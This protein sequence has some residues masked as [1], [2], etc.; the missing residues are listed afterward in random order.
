MDDEQASAWF[1]EGETLDDIEEVE[2]ELE[3]EPDGAPDDAAIP[4]LRPP[5]RLTFLAVGVGAALLLVLASV[6]GH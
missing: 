6:T 1:A 4:D 5:Y 3:A 2:A